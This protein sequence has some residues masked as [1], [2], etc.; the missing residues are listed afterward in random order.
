MPVETSIRP[1]LKRTLVSIWLRVATAL[2]EIV[3]GV[4]IIRSLKRQLREWAK[5][6][7]DSEVAA[8]VFASLPQSYAARTGRPGDVGVIG[9]AAWYAF[10]VRP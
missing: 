2:S 5:R 10:V 6:L 8:F 3:I 1:L 7:S 4:N 9:L